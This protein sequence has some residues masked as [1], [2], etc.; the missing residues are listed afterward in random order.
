MSLQRHLY[1]NHTGKLMNVTLSGLSGE[2][3]LT[4][5]Y[6]QDTFPPVNLFFPD[7]QITVTLVSNPTTTL[8]NI[9]PIHYVPGGGLD[10]SELDGQLTTADS[11]PATAALYTVKAWSIPTTA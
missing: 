3:R 8:S 5:Q 2:N 1:D 10:G 7:G 9:V 11:A 4:S 6:N